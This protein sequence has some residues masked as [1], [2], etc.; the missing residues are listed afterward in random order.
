MIE[1]VIFGQSS[2]IKGKYPKIPA[3]KGT[4]KQNKQKTL[5]V[6]QGVLFEPQLC[7]FG[8]G[9]QFLIF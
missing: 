1:Q 7:I 8:L 4:I 9:K 2:S 5:V 6:C 3:V